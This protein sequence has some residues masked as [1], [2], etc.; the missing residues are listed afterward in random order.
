MTKKKSTSA[1]AP[2]TS[3]DYIEATMRYCGVVAS[4]GFNNILEAKSAFIDDQNLQSART[5]PLNV[6]NK[7]IAAG[8][9]HVDL[10]RALSEL[11]TAHASISKNPNSIN[12][13]PQGPFNKITFDD[14]SL[15][16]VC[17]SYQGQNPNIKLK[18]VR[19][20]GSSNFKIL[21]KAP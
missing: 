1:D 11:R 8:D 13:Y 5:I 4:K 14:K 17:P 20:S 19:N 18:D 6:L 10:S 3:E 2:Y 9:P 7:L 16:E 12:L 15:G 21:P